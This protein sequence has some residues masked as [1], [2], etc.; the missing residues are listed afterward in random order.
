MKDV[1]TT[2]QVAKICKVTIRT[3]IK[4]FESGRLEGYKIP[5][6]KDRRIPRE[7][8]R[9]FLLEYGVPHDPRLFAT[10]PQLLIADDDL[11]ILELLHAHFAKQGAFDVH[12]AK[13]GY[14]A[15]FLTAKLKPYV[16]LLDYDLGDIRGSDVLEIVDRDGNVPTRVIVMTGYLCDSDIADMAATGLRVVK[17]PFDLGALEAEVLGLSRAAV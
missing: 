2:G 10:R 9:R 7:N 16:L 8:L 13:N 4:W 11:V 15:G 12:V 5:E 1:L 14:E 6:S 3:V 17:K